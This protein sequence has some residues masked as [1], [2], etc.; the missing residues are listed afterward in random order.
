MSKITLEKDVPLPRRTKLPDLPLNEMDIGHSFVLD[1]DK[2]GRSAV[3]QRLYRYQNA[4][5]PKRF[6]VRTLSDEQVRVY[7][8]KDYTEHDR[9]RKML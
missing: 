5:W 8:V 6:S 1:V 7:R 4:N 2:K 3:R 9:L